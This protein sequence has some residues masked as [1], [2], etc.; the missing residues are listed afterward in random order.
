MLRKTTGP[1]P[2]TGRTPIYNF[3]DWQQAH[4]AKSINNIILEKARKE[5]IQREKRATAVYH[6]QTN[7]FVACF[8]LFL[9]LN[10]IASQIPNSDDLVASFK[11][12]SD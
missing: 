1:S 6:K 2:S 11:K 3:D 10:A 5:N 12:K 8:V 9:L 4:Y 7:Y